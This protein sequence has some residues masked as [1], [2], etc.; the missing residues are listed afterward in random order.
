MRQLINAILDRLNSHGTTYRCYEKLGAR[1]CSSIA[2][3]RSLGGESLES[4]EVMT[5]LYGVFA[6]PSDTDTAYVA[7]AD[8]DDIRVRAVSRTSSSND[9]TAKSDD[10]TTARD[11]EPVVGPDGDLWICWEDADGQQS[12]CEPW[13][14]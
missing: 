11:L 12:V 1:D 4:R 14:Y 8:D 10:G 5:S 2:S 3:R 9:M 7:T 6:S 13:P